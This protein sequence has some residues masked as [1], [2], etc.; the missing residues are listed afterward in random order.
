MRV[1]TGVSGNSNDTFFLLSNGDSFLIL[2]KNENIHNRNAFHHIFFPTMQSTLLL[3]FGQSHLQ[4]PFTAH[5]EICIRIPILLP[6]ILTLKMAND[7]TE[8]SGNY[9]LKLLVPEGRNYTMNFSSENLRTRMNLMSCN[10]SRV[11]D[12]LSFNSSFSPSDRK[13]NQIIDTGL[14]SE[15]ESVIQTLFFKISNISSGSID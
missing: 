8:T 11:N 13:F 6:K 10:T 5:C 15:K 7:V 12:D 3:W 2:I 9:Y 1:S 4:F 14:S